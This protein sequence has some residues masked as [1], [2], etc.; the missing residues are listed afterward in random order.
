MKNNKPPKFLQFF[1]Y[2]YLIICAL[3]IVEAYLAYQEQSSKV[4]LML[5][6]ALAALFMFV[7]KRRFRKKRED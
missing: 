2:A 4:W 3:F 7:F 1:E 6:L 5:G